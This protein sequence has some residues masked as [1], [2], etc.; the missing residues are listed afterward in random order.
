MTL[1]VRETSS[2]EFEKSTSASTATSEVHGGDDVH[3]VEKLVCDFSVTTN[4]IGAVPSAISATR[5]LFDEI[6]EVHAPPQAGE[7]EDHTC[8]VS[9]PTIEHYPSR[10]DSDLL[11]ITGHFLRPNNEKQAQA[12]GENIIF[13]NG[14]SEVIDLVCRLAP[15]GNYSVSPHSRVQYREYERACRNAGHNYTEKSSEAMVTCLVNP[16]NPTGDFLEREQMEEW[17]EKE[18]ADGSW[19]IIDESMLFWAEEHWHTR[20]VSDEFVEKMLL[21]RGVRVFRVYSWTKI[22]S[23][24]GLRI[25][26]L[27]C[28][29]PVEK[30][31]IE[32]KQV[33]WTVN[34][35][36]K[37]YLKAALTDKLYME[38]TWK[39][40]LE[41]RR[42]IKTEL[43]RSFPHWK[44]FGQ[45]WTSW[46]WI[47]TGS[48]IEATRA[49][50]ASLAAGVPIRHAS[51]G[52]GLPTFI[53]VA[54]RRPSDFAVLHQ[55][56]QGLLVAPTN[57]AGAHR[58]A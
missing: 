45:P 23:C 55:T 27:L 36:A 24:T 43:E 7:V 5:K 10:E 35:L 16:T 34:T 4:A 19:F 13:G 29:S 51:A 48:E 39:Y 12:V 14:A 50:E 32:S 9:A 31:L 8:I 54:V 11:R 58:S 21:Q 56:F 1:S 37:T 46:L 25:G 40:T 33:P 17:I 15:P 38:Q 30:S 28:P 47:D 53:R 42:H 3:R 18:A 20:G 41:W 57:D 52:Y 6:V 22:F 44:I 2:K 26:S 49:Y